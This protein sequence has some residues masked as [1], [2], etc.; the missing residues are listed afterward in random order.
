MPKGIPKA[1]EV[2]GIQCIGCVF[3]DQNYIRQYTKID[4][5]SEK[6]FYVEVEI[7]KKKNGWTFAGVT[8]MAM[9]HQWFNPT[10][11]TKDIT[12]SD[13]SVESIENDDFVS[14]ITNVVESELNGAIV[15]TEISEEE[16]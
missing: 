1:K 3:L 16:E 4:C 9:Y 5:R 6:Q 15:E 13:H 8:G 11:K 14:A 2:A 12:K 7:I 10:R